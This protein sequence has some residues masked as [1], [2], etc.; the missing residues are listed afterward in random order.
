MC[1]FSWQISWFSWPLLNSWISSPSV[2]IYF[3]K[4]I[5]HWTTKL[6]SLLLRMY[7][8]LDF[9]TFPFQ[10]NHFHPLLF[11]KNYKKWIMK[12]V[13]SYFIL[14][15][16]TNNFYIYPMLCIMCKENQ[17]I[18]QFALL[19]VPI[20][21][22]QN[23]NCILLYSKYSASLNNYFKDL[24]ILSYIYFKYHFL[25]AYF[26]NLYYIKNNSLTL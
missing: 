4:V 6:G 18:N 5:R 13:L 16:Y 23:W 11:K 7:W 19:P 22:S 9:P 3:S 20:Q 15:M 1:T 24:I 25:I 21:A 12:Q 10:L 14:F 26:F 2:F 8:S 17:Y